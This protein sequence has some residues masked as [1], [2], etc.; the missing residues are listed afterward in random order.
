MAFISSTPRIH[1][2]VL[3]D[4]Q[5]PDPM[6]SVPPLPPSAAAQPAPQEP[7]RRIWCSVRQL[8]SGTSTLASLFTAAVTGTGGYFTPAPLGPWLWG[9]SGVSLFMAGLNGV[10]CACQ[11]S[12]DNLRKAL[13]A[14]VAKASIE[15]Q[16]LQS[17]I[18]DFQHQVEQLRR[19][20]STLESTV[21]HEEAEDSR[22][23][24]TLRA[25]E[26]TI[27]RLEG[28]LQAVQGQLDSTMRLKAEWEAIANNF[29][30][31]MAEFDAHIH[32]LVPNRLAR[33]EEGIDS[34]AHAAQNASL[35]LE[36]TQ[37]L[38]SKMDGYLHTILEAT[39][40]LRHSVG[41]LQQDV[42]R[43]KAEVLTQQ[44]SIEELRRT[45]AELQENT[46]KAQALIGQF[47]EL[48]VRY[49]QAQSRFTQVK[50]KL[51]LLEHPPEGSQ[52]TTEYVQR[53]V[54]EARTL[55]LQG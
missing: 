31:K 26:G 44:Q 47:Q 4:L 52:L 34:V 49:E 18:A 51:E 27:S 5:A 8:P 6:A 35:T 36:Q 30:K 32:E 29:I 25:H 17:S 48:V 1:L 41:T 10:A 43:K 28:Q 20:E 3:H 46:S 42:E 12:S 55:M 15:I 2:D 11:G 13:E 23:T 21:A 19:T 50:A 39:R 33:L 53:I 54:S 7:P 24:Q 45:N 16:R 14:A 9:A 38:Q 37:S 40:E 22:L